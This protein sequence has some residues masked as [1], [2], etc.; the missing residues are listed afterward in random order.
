MLSSFDT[1]SNTGMAVDCKTFGTRCIL[2]TKHRGIDRLFKS[3]NNIRELDSF[4]RH[5][6][7]SSNS[8]GPVECLSHH[9]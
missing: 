4:W 3:L 9:W 7:D 5:I 2:K 8:G 1:L 6:I